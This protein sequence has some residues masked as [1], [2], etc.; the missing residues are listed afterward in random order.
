M[1]KASDKLQFLQIQNKNVALQK[2][3]TTPVTTT[4]N[5]TRLVI[6]SGGTPTI[7]LKGAAKPNQPGGNTK[8]ITMS[9]AHQMGLITSAKYQEYLNKTNSAASNST[10]IAKKPTLVLPAGSTS[11]TLKNPPTILNK[12]VKPLQSPKI[13]IQT[14]SSNAEDNADNGDAQ[15]KQIAK[16]IVKVASRPQFRAVN[17][18]GKGM[19]YVQILNPVGASSGAGTTTT[20]TATKVV[21]GRQQQVIVQRKIVPQQG[22]QIVSANKQF[23]TKKLEVM[24][25]A[26]NAGTRII[27][28]EA[29][30]TQVVKA[31][32]TFLLN[33]TQ[34]NVV[35]S[36]IDVKPVASNQSDSFEITSEIK[37][38]PSSLNDS[39]KK[40]TQRT[41]SLSG[42]RKSKSP[43]PNQSNLLYSSLKL[44]SPE[45]IEG[46]HTRF[47]VKCFQFIVQIS[48]IFF[49]YS[50]WFDRNSQKTL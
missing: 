26:S 24:P 20:T 6:K 1:I 28:K 39:P 14:S 38:E 33:N 36:S 48:I 37:I 10:T 9:Q 23:V 44:P 21:N 46:K 15:P 22:T 12:G 8:S 40:F 7:I 19:Q 30:G 16:N 43:E 18:P 27:K 41:Y 34:K 31:P 13:L 29:T 3:A 42:E 25:I 2:G 47:V 17:V 50:P 4:S 11:V 49:F 5:N 45:P 35:T 32:P